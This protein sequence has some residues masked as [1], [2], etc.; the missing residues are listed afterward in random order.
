M[1]ELTLQEL[2]HPET[3][4]ARLY[5]KKLPKRGWAGRM[6]DTEKEYVRMVRA[7]RLTR[8]ESVSPLVNK[9]A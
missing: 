7:K 4:L 2:I 5:H 6:T 8:I 9:E 3:P 1:S